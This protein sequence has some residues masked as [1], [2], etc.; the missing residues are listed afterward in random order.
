M[1]ADEIK[2]IDE[3]I[4]SYQRMIKMHRQSIIRLSRQKYKEREFCS[5]CFDFKVINESR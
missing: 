4:E 5:E 3:C 2:L 1:N